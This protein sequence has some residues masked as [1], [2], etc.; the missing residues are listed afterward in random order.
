MKYY[1]KKYHNYIYSYYHDYI[2][3][4]TNYGQVEISD[5]DELYSII[6]YEETVN[7]AFLGYYNN[8]SSYLENCAN[9]FN[10]NFESWQ[11]ITNLK[12]KE[13]ERILFDKRLEDKALKIK[14]TIISYQSIFKKCNAKMLQDEDIKLLAL[15]ILTYDAYVFF[16]KLEASYFYK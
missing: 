15:N 16:E 9:K 4:S 12:S 8:K 7:S 10:K 13:E 1:T 11:V 6:G 5:V 3:D 14:D 2:K